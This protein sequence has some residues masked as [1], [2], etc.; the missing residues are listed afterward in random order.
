MLISSLQIAY[1]LFW[2]WLNLKY[3]HSFQ[4]TPVCLALPFGIDYVGLLFP[5][6][7]D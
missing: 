6:L 7:F 1:W 2:P 5:D 4:G 3:L